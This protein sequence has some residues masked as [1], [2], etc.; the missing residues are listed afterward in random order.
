MEPARPQNHGVAAVV[1]GARRSGRTTLTE[2][3]AQQITL[4]MGI[5]VPLM[6][7]V[8]RPEEARAADLPGTRVVVKAI[9][10]AHKTDR[11]GVAITGNSPAEIADAAGA[12]VASVPELEGL[13]VAEFIEHDPSAEIIA[14]VRW[15][16]A[17][18]PVVTIGPG[19]TTVGL[20]LPPALVAPATSGRIDSTLSTAPGTRLLMEGIRG[21]A[22]AA[23]AAGLTAL[24]A[25]LLALGEATMPHDLVE[26]ELNPLVF[27]EGRPI[28]LDAFAVLGRGPAGPATPRPDAEAIARQLRPHSIAVIGVSERMN[29]GRLILRNILAAGFPSERV[30]VIKPDIDDIDGCRCIADTSALS[31]P[32]DLLVVAVAA[33]EVVPLMQEVVASASARSVVL[34]PGGLGERPGT[35]RTLEQMAT[36]ILT[37]RREGRPTP[38]VTGPNSM[39]IR[40]LPGRYDATFI[41]AER[42]TPAPGREEPVAMIA[43]SGAFTLSRL[44]RLPW[45][46]PRHV[47]TVGNQ[48]DLTVGD[49]LEHF[50]DDAE[51]SIV[52]CY[53]EGFRPGDGDRTLRAAARIKERGGTL[54]W[55]RGGRTGPG[56]RSA[57]SHTAAIATDDRAARALGEAA[58]VL[59]AESLDDFDDLLR[60]AVLL[61][62]TPITG[63][64]VGVVSNAGFECVS[65]ADSLGSLELAE[66]STATRTRLGAIVGEAGLGGITGAANPLDLTPS[67]DDG[68]FA[69][70]VE[71]VLDDPAVDLAVVGCVPFSPELR[72]LPDDVDAAGSLTARLAAL[73]G[74]R[75]P[76]VAV[77][78]GGRTYDPMADR[79]EVAGVPVLR[80]MDRAIRL[81]GRYAETR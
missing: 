80:S 26:Y 40:S 22:P 7:V 55:Y 69:A 16:D 28:A 66:L 19:G 47:V 65:A 63:R 79:L 17:F 75:T 73:A 18:G 51:I 67:A 68:T 11:D 74:H 76:W 8:S 27:V 12:I 35:E 70:A 24:A 44:D 23:S 10:P 6:R 60:I 78:D 49:Y 48:L 32:V 57:A 36:E 9:G 25:D 30:V 50:A 46:R 77:V 13:L 81:L 1:A 64:R 5:A 31:E 59:E 42:M 58:G 15:T 52:A 72:T 45:L 3:E 56:A 53:L 37:A 34:I 62:D 33:S 41:P 61:R 2:P 71:A 38:V 54:L 21:R 20:G 43:Q 29:P 14:G 39:G 4:G